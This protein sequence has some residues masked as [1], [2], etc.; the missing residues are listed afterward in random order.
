MEKPMRFLLTLTTATLGATL[1]FASIAAA[2]DKCNVP[3][4]DWQPRA[5]LQAK[6]EAEGWK[7]RSIKTEDGC[8]EAYAITAKG[9]KVEAYFDPKSLAAVGM[10]VE[11]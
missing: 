7:V 2:K 5:T 9:E 3:V 11:N 4:A 8:Y 6:L 1:A 10:K